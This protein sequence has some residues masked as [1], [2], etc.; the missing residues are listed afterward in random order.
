MAES[1]QIY[2]NPEHPAEFTG[3]KKL[4]LCVNKNGKSAVKDHSL[5]WLET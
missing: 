3:A 4:L 5:R 2:N 1:A